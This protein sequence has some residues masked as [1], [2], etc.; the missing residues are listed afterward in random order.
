MHYK[1]NPVLWIKSNPILLG[2]CWFTFDL[3]YFDLFYFDLFYL[4]WHQKK[5]IQHNV[6]K[7]WL[8]DITMCL[9]YGFWILIILV[10]FSEY[11]FSKQQSLI[12][13]LVAFFKKAVYT[14]LYSRIALT[15][16]VKTKAPPICASSTSLTVLS[17]QV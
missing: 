9:S 13:L 10:T 3:F 11:S 14:W 5:I 7:L 2:S 4:S 8:L 6:P 17:R 15:Y 1:C 12:G 16:L